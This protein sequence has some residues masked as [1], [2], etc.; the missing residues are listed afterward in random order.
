MELLDQTRQQQSKLVGI[1]RVDHGSYL[2]I[3]S[4]RKKN[5]NYPLSSTPAP[6]GYDIEPGG[7]YEPHFCHLKN[8]P[9]KLEMKIRQQRLFGLRD[10]HRI[11]LVDAMISRRSSK[12]KRHRHHHHDH[13][14]NK[15]KVTCQ[16]LTAV[17]VTYYFCGRCRQIQ[18]G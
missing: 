11:V 17:K 7:D 5:N 12:D 4:K 3:S 10:S 16:K 8:R 6:V 14:L 2:P 18:R 15:C 1:Q 13:L 9:R